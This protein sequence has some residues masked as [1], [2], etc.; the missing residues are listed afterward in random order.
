MVDN[1]SH[2]NNSWNV[3]KHTVL[4]ILLD[5]M[6]RSRPIAV[7]VQ[8]GLMFEQIASVVDRRHGYG[9]VLFQQI[10]VGGLHAG[11]GRT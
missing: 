1:R 10:L 7:P 8:T 6:L 9:D 3:K 11:K 5:V 4:S 2:L